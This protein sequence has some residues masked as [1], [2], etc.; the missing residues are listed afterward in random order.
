VRQT[1]EVVWTYTLS[2]FCLHFVRFLIFSIIIIFFFF[3]FSSQLHVFFLLRRHNSETGSCQATC[4][5]PPGCCWLHYS[6]TGPP[7]EDMMQQFAIVIVRSTHS[8]IQ[9]HC[10]SVAFSSSLLSS[11]LIIN[12]ARS[13][14]GHVDVN[15]ATSEDCKHSPVGRNSVG[16][17]DVLCFCIFVFSSSSS[18]SLS[19]YCVPPAEDLHWSGN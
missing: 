1:C 14:P 15:K 6:A 13:G 10:F 12:R 3:F 11:F 17:Q 5:A 16:A 2:F 9:D 4:K 18:S 19:F 8:P 7:G